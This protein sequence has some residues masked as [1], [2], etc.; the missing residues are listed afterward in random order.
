MRPLD[1]TEVW[2]QLA[3]CEA[4]S[5]RVHDF[6]LTKIGVKRRCLVRAMHITVYYS[7]RPMPSLEAVTESA[8]VIIPAQ[9]MRFMVMAPGGE[10]PRPEIDPAL[11]KVG[12]RVH[13]PSAA[14][15]LIRAYRDRLLRH[16]TRGVLGKRAPSTHA[17]NAFGARH[18]QPHMSVLR[19]GS[20]VDRNL[21]VIGDQFRESLGSLTF[22]TFLIDIV[23]KAPG[24]PR[25]SSCK[26]IS[27]RSF[28]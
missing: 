8:S 10:N 18:F 19:A 21:K 17:A 25:N 13:R 28:S 16:E 27:R 1:T 6:F 5:V 22:D 9:D 24:G 11:R 23:R 2:A 26:P 20:G 12:V 3:L 7:R 14:T 15:P 4:D